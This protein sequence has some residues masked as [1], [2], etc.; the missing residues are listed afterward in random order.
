MSVRV[1]A[2]ELLLFPC[3]HT[4]QLGLL[5]LFSGLISSFRDKRVALSY[6]QAS[7]HKA[8][9]KI[10]HQCRRSSSFEDLLCPEMSTLCVLKFEPTSECIGNV[11][12]GSGS[13]K[14]LLARHTVLLANKSF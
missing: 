7:P 13:L 10:A 8:Q 9:A 11:I 5:C 14:L 3:I 12:H 4:F 2:P 1:G 6:C